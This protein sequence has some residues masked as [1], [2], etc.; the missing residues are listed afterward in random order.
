MPSS[1]NLAAALLASLD[2]L[3]LDELADRLAPKLAERLVAREQAPD[4]WLTSKQ[5]AAYLGISVNALHK[6]TSARAVP[7]EQDAPGC[8]AWFRRSSL[9]AWREAGGA[10]AQASHA[11]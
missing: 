7:F 1:P 10:R 9:D 2:D 4:E 5:A 11:A 3:A 8:K 6:L